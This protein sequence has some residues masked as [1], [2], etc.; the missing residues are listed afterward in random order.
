MAQFKAYSPNVEVNGQTVLSIVD[1]MGSFTMSANQ[2]LS[3]N[4]IINPTP[5]QWY[6]Q[7][8][9]LNAF[10]EISEKL[11]PKTLL[12]I[13]KKIPENADFPPQID[14]IEKAL[15]AIDVAYHMNHRNGEIGHYH[16]SKTGPNNAKLVCNNPYPCE[17]DRGIIL[18]M[19]QRFATDGAHVSVVH[20]ENQPCRKKGDE[21]CTYLV[22]W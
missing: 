6:S 9:W 22:T 16:Y 3:Q 18:A 15:S 19:A 12:S 11:G 2:I 7:Q 5:G 20:D 17:F 14:D 4:G 13:G 8:N 21:S 10:K 1:G